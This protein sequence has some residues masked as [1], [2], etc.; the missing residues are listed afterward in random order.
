MWLDCAC[1]TP[2][3]KVE[4]E[5]VSLPGQSELSFKSRDSMGKD[6]ALTVSVNWYAMNFLIRV[7]A[8]ALSSPICRQDTWICVCARACVCACVL[9]HLAFDS[10]QVWIPGNR[11]ETVNLCWCL[12]VPGRW[13]ARSFDLLDTRKQLLLSDVIRKL[14]RASRVTGPKNNNQESVLIFLIKSVKFLIGIKEVP[15]QKVTAGLKLLIN[16]E[17]LIIRLKVQKY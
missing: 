4:A 8:V 7:M 16:S 5:E 13:W 3:L 15:S 10:P 6:P 11:S 2:G 17:L 12:Q 14:F 1:V 9:T